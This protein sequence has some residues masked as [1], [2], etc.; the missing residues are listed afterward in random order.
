MLSYLAAAPNDK[1][2]VC[3]FSLATDANDFLYAGSWY[4]YSGEMAD[5]Y[6]TID[7]GTSWDTTGFGRGVLSFAVSPGELFAGTDEGLF[8]TTD[9]GD[10]WTGVGIITNPVYSVAVTP[11]GALFVGS[12]GGTRRSL[13]G[14]MTWEVLLA[15]PAT[16]FLVMNADTI[17]AGDDG[18]SFPWIGMGVF[19]ST[20]AGNTW[21]QANSGLGS[22]SI[23]SFA[24]NTDNH[25]FA[26]T[27]DGLFVSTDL[28]ESWAD[29]SDGLANTHITCIVLDSSDFAYVGTSGGG[30]YR[31]AGPTTSVHPDFSLL[32]GSFQLAQNYP[33]PFNPTTT[34]GFQISDYGLVTL[35]VYDLLG[36]EVATI[37]NER[38]EPGTYTRQ[39]D[40]AGLAS[41]VYL[42]RLISLDFVETRKLV[43]IR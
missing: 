29:F 22:L 4:P 11:D 14:G 38:L 34:I 12:W 40:A 36:R 35:K 5:I 21:A 19:R 43:L 31:S 25:I 9:H 20:D 8:R 42:Y 27:R 33:N 10:S 41:G 3:S 13:D 1:Q 37:V 6:R 30:L 2:N 39:W 23:T 26:G 17:L 7:E 18:L 24:R 32:P 16:D 28:G 15:T